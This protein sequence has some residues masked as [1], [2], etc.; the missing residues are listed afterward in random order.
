MHI[1]KRF[2]AVLPD[3]RMASVIPAD[4]AGDA[5]VRVTDTDPWSVLHNRGLIDDAEWAAAERHAEVWRATELEEEGRSGFEARAGSSRGEPADR[6]D[7]PQMRA[8][9]T[10]KAAQAAVPVFARGQIY[11]V[12][13]FREAPTNMRTLRI[14][15]RALARFYRIG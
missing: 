10:W 8:W 14:G 1:A 11:S 3:G 6:M 13:S 7:A 12:T 2:D 5:L 9:R 15:L 4:C